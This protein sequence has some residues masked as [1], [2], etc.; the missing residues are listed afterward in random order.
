MSKLILLNGPI[1][2]G[3]TAATDVIKDRFAPIWPV[4]CK[5]HLHEL[6]R[7]LFNVPYPTYWTIYEDRTLKEQPQPEF[8]LMLEEYNK[9]ARLLGKPVRVSPRKVM[10]SI[11]EAMIYVSEIVCKPAFGEDYFGR[12]RASSIDISGDDAIFIDDSAGFEEEVPPA[13]ERLGQDNI[14]LI[15]V[16]GRGTFDGDSRSY[17]PDGLCEHT[18][19]VYNTASLDEFVNRVCSYVQGFVNRPPR[20]NPCNA[21]AVEDFRLE[22]Q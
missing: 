9:L 20:L 4:H 14:L 18:V 12:V 6:T 22:V 1:G 10:I 15:R 3:K 13:I 16:R 7:S 2:C 5:D 17:L 19:D 8:Q 21:H 11:R